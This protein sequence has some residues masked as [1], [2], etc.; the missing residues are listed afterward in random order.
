MAPPEASPRRAERLARLTG[1]YAIVGGPDAVEQARLALDGGAAV[2]QLRL[3]EAPAGEVLAAARRVV[4]LSRG[5]ALVVVNDRADLAVLAGADG[6]HV[7]DEDLPVA[8][9]RAV[10]GP[11]L[12]V[13]RSTRTLDDGLAA[14][15]DGADH[16]GF[17]PIFATATKSIAASPRGLP[18][19]R[20]VAARLPAPVVAIGG[21]GLA[22]IGDVAASGAAAAA[23]IGDL[24]G[25]PD[26]RARAAALAAAFEAGRRRR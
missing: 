9:A 17:G 11:D 21:I 18:M 25:D 10:V 13:G 6:V 16:V 1:L 4:E 26:P 8:E 14:L 22:T 23:V 7:G 12:L 3:K 20:E 19:L 5:R 24:F 2:V 15:A